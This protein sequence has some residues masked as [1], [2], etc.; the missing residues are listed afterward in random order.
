VTST[1]A[2]LTLLKKRKLE[3]SIYD[4]RGKNL[5]AG[6]ELLQLIRED[7]YDMS[8]FIFAGQDRPEFRREAA[9]RGAQLST[10]DMLELVGNIVKYLGEK[11]WCAPRRA[12]TRAAL[13]S[14][15][16]TYPLLP[17]LSHNPLVRSTRGRSPEASV[18]GE[19]MRSH[20][21]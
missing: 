19:R 17:N 14:A 4:G 3:L 7:G 5:R 18:N 21:C 6:Y 11:G 9:A 2:A 20:R 15:P 13:L 12:A 16:K 10:N 8:F 1:E